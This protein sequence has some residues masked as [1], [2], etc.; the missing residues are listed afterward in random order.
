MFTIIKKLPDDIVGILISGK[1]TK[2]DY[3]R[4][5]P[6]MD[7]YKQEHKKIKMLMEI[8]ELD[9]TAK[10][11]WEEL[12]FDFKYLGT[13]SA[14][15]I[16]SDKKWL[17]ESLQAF[18]SIVPGISAKGFESDQVDEAIDWLQKQ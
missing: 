11:F 7:Q 18:G 15:A 8:V 14:L 17:E 9:Y 16:I 2:E 1:T 10:A 3:D 4:I 12:K 5:N 13:I 6:I